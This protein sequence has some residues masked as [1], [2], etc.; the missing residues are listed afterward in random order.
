[1]F[2]KHFLTVHESGSNEKNHFVTMLSNPESNRNKP[3]FENFVSRLME[4]EK[5]IGLIA[6]DFCPLDSKSFCDFLDKAIPKLIEIGC[7]ESNVKLY[8]PLLFQNKLQILKSKTCE[9]K[10]T[11]HDY[12]LKNIGDNFDEEFLFIDYGVDS[13]VPVLKNTKNKKSLKKS[14][15]KGI[16][17]L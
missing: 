3:H 14:S 12:F 5:P 4:L 1:M 9:V 11:E 16:N 8:L 7:V 15:A 17:V 2:G 6:V 13:N 10:K